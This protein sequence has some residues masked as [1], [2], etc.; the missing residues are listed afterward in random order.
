MN[1]LP[2][3][4]RSAVVTGASRRRDIGAAVARRLLQMGARVVAH[5][6]QPH[7]ADQPWGA[8]DLAAVDLHA[9]R[10]AFPGGHIGEPDGP[11]R[12]IAW[13]VTAD[14]NWVVGQV[15][16]TEGGFRRS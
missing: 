10:H 9:V 6:H 2:L 11:A 14:A 12:L 16:H 4:G 13:L 1:Q 8:D 5:H 3:A 7:D 15:L